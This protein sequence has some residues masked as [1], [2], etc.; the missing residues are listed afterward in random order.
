MNTIKFYFSSLMWT[1]SP[2]PT[3]YTHTHTHTHTSPFTEHIPHFHSH[4][5]V[6]LPRPPCTRPT[7]LPPTCYIMLEHAILQLM[8][9]KRCSCNIT[10]ISMLHICSDPP[11]FFFNLKKRK[12][13][14][15]FMTLCFL[16]NCTP[17]GHLKDLTG[18][19]YLFTYTLLLY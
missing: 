1:Y 2:W 15:G 11:N 19:T 4:L 5:N 12:D 13:V 7:P 16:E 18:N 14:F 6:P 17:I 3:Y 9:L 8:H 10:K